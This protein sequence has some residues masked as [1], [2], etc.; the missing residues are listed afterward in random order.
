MHFAY[1]RR[2][3]G[4]PVRSTLSLYF[5]IIIPRPHYY[6]YIHMVLKAF[7]AFVSSGVCGLPD[8]IIGRIAREMEKSHTYQYNKHVKTEQKL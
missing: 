4:N 8:V 5:Y 6:T 1:T 2:F 7:T 3:Q